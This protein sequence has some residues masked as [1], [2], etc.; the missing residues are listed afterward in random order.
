MVK[1]YAGE[2]LVTV[3]GGLPEGDPCGAGHFHS[4]RGREEVVVRAIITWI[5]TGK[6]ERSVGEPSGG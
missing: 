1:Q 2:N 3:R 5:K 4:Y 6:V